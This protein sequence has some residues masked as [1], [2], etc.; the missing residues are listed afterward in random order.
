MDLADAF[1]RIPR[2]RGYSVAVVNRTYACFDCR[3]SLLSDGSSE[4]VS[5]WSLWLSKVSLGLYLD[6]KK[7]FILFGF[8]MGGFERGCVRTTAPSV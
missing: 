7:M 3:L 6:N 5:P 8:M 2:P 4:I 1:F